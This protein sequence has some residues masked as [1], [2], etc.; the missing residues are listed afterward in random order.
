MAGMALGVRAET[1]SALGVALTLLI[2]RPLAGRQP[3]GGLAAATRCS[4]SGP[5]SMRASSPGSRPARLHARDPPRRRGAGRPRVS[6]TN[7]AGGDLRRRRRGR[8]CCSACSPAPWSWSCS[9]RR[10]ARS[11]LGPGVRRR[12]LAIASPRR[13][14]LTLVNPA[15]PGIY[16]YIAETIGN[17]LLSQLVSEWQSPNFHDTLTRLIEVVA[18]LLVLFWL[19]GR[20]PR[21]PDALLATAALLLTLQAVRNV[22]IFAVVAIPQLAEYGAAA[23]NAR[24]PLRLRRRLG[25]RLPAP[26]AVVAAVAVSAASIA[27][28]APQVS[29]AA[30]S[31]VRADPRARQRGRLRRGPLPRP[32]AAQLGRRR[33]LPRLPL[34]H[35][36]RGVRVRRDRTL[37]DR[38]AH[39]LR[40]HR[41]HLRRLEG[42]DR[43]LRH[44]PRHPRHR[45][46]RR[47]RPPGARLDGQL[48]RRGQ[49]P[50]GHVGGRP[51]P[52]LDATAAVGC[53]R[54]LAWPGGRASRRS[55]RSCPR[56]R[57]RRRGCRRRPGRPH[58]SAKSDPWRRASSPTCRSTAATA[59]RSSGVLA[60][61]V[62]SWA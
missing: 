31:P 57:R 9:G 22:S 52:H 6:A 58:R 13:A 59:R 50:G 30:A 54:L 4:C 46:R 49:R 2:V 28:A 37:R 10:S 3:L 16:G 19:L 53:P 12:P 43:A 18:A 26:L 20:R 7:L 8:R 60:A 40:R 21:V 45:E 11:R 55:G 48:L 62:A 27:V 61:R 5:T 47:L 35:R 39:R 15:G 32:A 56:P 51:A 24:A 29:A 36:P 33:R 41:H 38:P 34:P 42:A 1:V 23:W 14:V 25:A 17:P 44:P